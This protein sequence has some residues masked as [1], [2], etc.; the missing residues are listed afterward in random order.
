MVLTTVKDADVRPCMRESEGGMRQNH[1]RAQ[2]L[3][4]SWAH[5]LMGSWASGLMQ[6]E[7]G[8]DVLALL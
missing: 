1:S 5:G 3:M 4:G 6:V 7:S 2:G 8:H